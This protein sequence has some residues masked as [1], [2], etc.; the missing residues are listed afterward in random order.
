M[1]TIMPR[2]ERSPLPLLEQMRKLREASLTT[3]HAG[4]TKPSTDSEIISVRN[5]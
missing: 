1:K 5:V 3:I 2:K 4:E